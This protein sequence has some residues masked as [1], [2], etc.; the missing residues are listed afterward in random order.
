[1][2]RH[3]VG[4][5]WAAARCLQPF[6]RTDRKTRPLFRARNSGK[7][8]AGVGVSTLIV[9]LLCAAPAFA[10][11]L[12]LDGQMEQGGLVRGHTEPAATVVLDGRRVRVAPDGAFIF[13]FPRNAPAQASLDVTYRDGGKLHRVLSV[14]PQHYQIQRI[15]GLPQNEVSPNPE[16]LKRILHD[17][18]AIRAAHHVDS[19]N[20]D[21]EIA[22]R[23][24]VIGPISG[25]FG[26]QRILNGEPRAPHAGVDIVAPAGTRV[27]APAGGVVTLAE[28]D[29]VL[30]GATVIVDHGYGLSTLYIHL[31]KITV[32]KG[33]RVA[34][35][36]PIGA[37]GATG[38]A[39]GANL[40]WGVYWYEMALDPM[41]AAGPMPTR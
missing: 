41:L 20:R 14:A 33:E 40:H 6:R 28:P 29:L 8:K 38:R 35:G 3:R 39:T 9:A 7:A 23:W 2:K 19:D 25:V 10:N 17:I 32:H 15:N 22:L 12:A 24:P 4:S 16:T 11:T 37:V 13:G 18:A 5:E 21:F 36:Q 30:D 1:L 27:V 31:S 34:Q 26:S